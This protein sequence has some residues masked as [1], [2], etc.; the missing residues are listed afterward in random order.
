MIYPGWVM[1]G[2]TTRALCVDGRPTGKISVHEKGEMPVEICA[3]LIVRAAA[4]RR[5]EVVMTHQGKVGL[6]MRLIAP[7][8]VD[9][10]AKKATGS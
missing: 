1:T 2:I 10:A 8:A 5:R 6:W 3:G 9:R 7:G 4:R